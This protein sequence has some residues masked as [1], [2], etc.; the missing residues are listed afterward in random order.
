MISNRLS[1]LEKSVTLYGETKACPICPVRGAEDRPTRVETRAKSFFVRFARES[2]LEYERSSPARATSDL[3]RLMTA[4]ANILVIDDHRATRETGSLVVRHAGF[5]VATAETGRE[6]VG[7][8]VAGSFDLILVDL[9]LPDISGIEVLRELKLNKV[10]ANVVIV[11]AFPTF[12]TSFDAGTLAADGYVAGLLLPDELVEAVREACAKRLPVRHPQRSVARQL[13]PQDTP[14]SQI[15]PRVREVMGMVNSDLAV[16]P[17]IATYAAKVGLSESGL[18][19]LFRCSTGLSVTQ[20]RLLRR[21]Q[22]VSARLRGGYEDVRQI[23]YAVGF[24][25][26]SLREFRRAFRERFGMSP[27]TYRT[28]LGRRN[29]RQS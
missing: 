11:T 23:A 9:R 27:T 26:S 20:Y 2:F 18:R 17:P 24:R 3:T 12:E 6:G 25:S 1:P 4:L 13:A 14:T 8:A 5:D 29:Q 22:V 15:D 7:L 21:L 19:H 16:L 28:Q 10:C